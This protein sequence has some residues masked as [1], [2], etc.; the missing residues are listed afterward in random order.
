MTTGGCGG[1]VGHTGTLG[2]VGGGHGITT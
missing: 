2:G 1:G